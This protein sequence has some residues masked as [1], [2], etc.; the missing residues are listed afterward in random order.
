M[1]VQETVHCRACKGSGHYYRVKDRCKRCKGSCVVSET[2]ILEFVIPKG[3]PS[4][5]QVVLKGEADEEPGLKT[6][7]A[8]LQYTCKDHPHFV[9]HKHDL[10]TKISITLVDAL[11]GFKDRKL[12]KSLDHRYL[13]V[14]VPTGKVLKP[15]DSI[16]VPGEGMPIQGSYSRYGDLYV[17]VEIEFPKDHWYLEKND[18][19]KLKSILDI[20]YGE[21]TNGNG[22]YMH[23]MPNTNTTT[24]SEE[25][26]IDMLDDDEIV[27]VNFKV[28]SKDRLPKSFNSFYNNSE[29]KTFG[30]DDDKL[31]KG[32]W[33][34]RWF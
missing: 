25:D 14:S 33:F 13:F 6:G 8:I 3:S 30:V 15:G 24:D 29:V 23:N 21:R 31:K 11:C 18:V 32:G 27:N 20:S 2:K 12:V 34:G 26:D 10:Y 9:R 28:Q 17:G 5:G 19:D 1:T 22:V 4:E 16:I 7:D